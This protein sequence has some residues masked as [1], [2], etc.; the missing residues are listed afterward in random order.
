MNIEDIFDLSNQKD[1]SIKMPEMV[2]GFEPKI[3]S[4]P[5]ITP[6][7]AKS[8]L[9]G[10][11]EFGASL[12]PGG[13]IADA[14][15]FAANPFGEGK[16]PSFGENVLD[17]IAQFQQGNYVSGASKGLE[18]A[19]QA[20]GTAGDTVQMAG[21]ASGV[22]AIPALAIGAGM[23]LP[24]KAKRFLTGLDSIKTIPA[25]G[26]YTTDFTNL[27]KSFQEERPDIYN[28]AT[29]MMNNNKLP[30]ESIVKMINSRLNTSAK[31]TK[32]PTQQNL[33]FISDTSDS[34]NQKL[35]GKDYLRSNYE[36]SFERPIHF[37]STIVAQDILSK[38]PDG[39]TGKEIYKQIKN[40]QIKDGGI[41]DRE[42]K[43]AGLDIL[44]DSDAK[45]MLTPNNEFLVP[46]TKFDLN[47][48]N[49]ISRLYGPDVAEH[50][51]SGLTDLIPLNNSPIVSRSRFLSDHKNFK[52][53]DN[54]DDFDQIPF[55]GSEPFRIRD[56]TGP[57]MFEANQRIGGDA[58]SSEIIDY[59]MITINDP[60]SSFKPI[61]ASEQFPKTLSDGN[62]AW[63]RVSIRVGPDGKK[64]LVPEEFQSDLHTKAQGT[65]GNLGKGYK[66]SKYEK[67]KLDEDYQEKSKIFDNVQKDLFDEIRKPFFNEHF[68]SSNPNYSG[69]PK[70]V[71]NEMKPNYSVFGE[72]ANDLIRLKELHEDAVIDYLASY[73][74]IGSVWATNENFNSVSRR[75]SNINNKNP[76]QQNVL[77]NLEIQNRIPSI[78]KYVKEKD[79]LADKLSKKGEDI[80]LTSLMQKGV[81]ADAKDFSQI[82]QLDQRI[83]DLINPID[84]DLGIKAHIYTGVWKTLANLKKDPDFK[85]FKQ[86]REEAFGKTFYGQGA[87]AK[88]RQEYIKNAFFENADPDG[89]LELADH[90]TLSFNDREFNDLINH[91]DI[92]LDPV[93]FSYD[94]YQNVDYLHSIGKRTRFNVNKDTGK[95]KKYFD[96]KTNQDEAFQKTINFSDIP[97]SPLPGQSQWTKVLMRDLMRIAADKDLDGVVLP[98]A[99]AYKM[100]GGRD[101]KLITGYEKTT[102]PAFKEIAKEMDVDV[103]PIE[104]KG[105]TSGNHMH[106][107]IPVNKD[108]SGLS[109][110]GYKQGGQ[111]GSLANIN[112][113][114]L[115]ESLNG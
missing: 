106:L 100:A 17:T 26:E 110:R 102:I 91:M 41:T 11:T 20:L 64:Y 96:S 68:S 48:Y 33:N 73:P 78:D 95:I 36:G 104:W 74:V 98:N 80:N 7:K 83:V 115:G 101:D 49:Q 21:I 93:K 52:V 61:H 94:V 79:A 1:L 97:Y 31:V 59:G 76:L 70:D 28:A 45:F 35:L 88:E 18:S 46:V 84:N 54:P 81:N 3:S 12:G 39:L 89:S 10:I 71:S 53:Q 42:L 23:K 27:V 24:L 19:L 6:E 105:W 60:N 77:V 16:L 9:T 85:A 47:K 82:S 8:I 5:L 50:S 72:S 99:Q 13:G 37:N 38:N 30:E 75:V 62:I 32:A 112:I 51:I 63:S 43:D 107:M 90:I 2:A 92:I 58:Q 34:Y 114:D 25:K 15:G 4:A 66:L 108:L 56:A 86:K 57:K 111:V 55:G 14:A 113:L 109:V 22:G 67:L 87:S 29:K 40:A 69:L 44:K 65:K 103:E